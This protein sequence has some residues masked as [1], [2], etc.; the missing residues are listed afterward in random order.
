MKPFYKPSPITE[1]KLVIK[2]KNFQFLPRDPPF[3]DENEYVVSIPSFEQNFASTKFSGCFC[4]VNNHSDPFSVMGEQH[5]QTTAFCASFLPFGRYQEAAERGCCKPFHITGA[6]LCDIMRDG[7]PLEYGGFCAVCFDREV[8]CGGVTPA[9][10]LSKQRTRN[11]TP[12]VMISHCK[13][14]NCFCNLK[15]CT[16]PMSK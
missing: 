16:K 14:D 2:Q 13:G 8:C 3:E 11:C 15:S 6:H 4:S 7:D 5:H 12:L 1:R 9:L 10:A